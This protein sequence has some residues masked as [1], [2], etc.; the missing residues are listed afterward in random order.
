MWEGMVELPVGVGEITVRLAVVRDDS[1]GGEGEGEGDHGPGP[2][3]GSSAASPTSAASPKSPLSP[4]RTWTL[5]KFAKHAH[6]IRLAG[7]RPLDVVATCAW[8][9][10]SH[11]GGVLGASAFSGVFGSGR[12]DDHDDH[13]DHGDPL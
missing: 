6:V 12:A 3:P 13:D 10:A 11:P 7:D 8:V 5:V 1:Q 4:K 9:D 2:G